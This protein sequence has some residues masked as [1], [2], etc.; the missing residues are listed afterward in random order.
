MQALPQTSSAWCQLS[1][2]PA[3]VFVELVLPALACNVTDMH[4]LHTL[5]N[6]AIQLAA[7]LSTADQHHLKTTQELQPKVIKNY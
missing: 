3:E 6:S 2:S 5:D 7:N 4:S 1:L